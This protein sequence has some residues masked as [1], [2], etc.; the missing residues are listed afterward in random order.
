MARVLHVEAP[1]EIG[2]VRCL[3]ESHDGRLGWIV[4]YAEGGRSNVNY[5]PAEEA[6]ALRSTLIDPDEASATE[7]DIP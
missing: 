3:V 2:N 7:E 4:Y 1:N 6:E 5:F